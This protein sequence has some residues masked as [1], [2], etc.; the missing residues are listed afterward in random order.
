MRTRGFLILLVVVG[1]LI[2]CSAS[3]N[4]GD[5]QIISGTPH[6]LNL[7][8]YYTYDEID[9]QVMRDVFQEASRL[10]Y[11]GT[12]GQMQIGVVR[13]SKKATFNNKA[14]IWVN[15]GE[16]GAS[17]NTG[18]MGTPGL[19]ITIY[20]DQHR[21]TNNDGPDNDERGQFGIVHES[22]HYVFNLGDEYE[23]GD[24]IDPCCLEDEDSEIAC[25]M[26]GGTTTNNTRT[27]FCSQDGLGLITDHNPNNE[28]EDRHGESCW[29][30]AVDRVLSEFGIT[31]TAPSAAN[32][33]DTAMPAGHQ[34][35]AWIVVGDR[36]RYVICIDKSYSMVGSK[37]DLT[38]VA[39]DLFVD[40]VHEGEEEFLG[41]TSFSDLA[42]A[43]FPIAEVTDA[44]VKANARDAIADV[45]V[46]NNTAMGDGLRL[47]LNQ[48]TGSGAVPRDDSNIETIILLSDGVHN[49]GS[50]D[51]NDVIPD[52]KDRGVRVFTI[53]LGDPDA[54]VYPLDEETLQEI[55]DLTGGLYRHTP[56]ETELAAVYTEYAAEVRGDA[57]D[58]EATDWM[59]SGEL[60]ETKEK[61]AFIDSFT[62]E[63]T[64][65]LH[66]PAGYNAFDLKL[67]K[68]GGAM[69]DPTVA[70]GNPKI[71]HW[72]QPFYEYY[73]VRE[74]EVGNWK[75][76]VSTAAGT[77]PEREARLAVTVVPPRLR[78]TTQ[79]ICSSPLVDLVVYTPEFLYKYPQVPVIRASV[80]AGVPVAGASVEGVV[81][82]PKGFTRRVRLYDDGQFSHGDDKA[83][84]GVYSNHFLHFPKNGG[85]SF[86]LSVENKNGVEAQPDEV[87]PPDWQPKP[88][89]PFT[90]ISKS[91][92]TIS[93]VPD[94][95][96]KPEIEG[97]SPSTGRYGKS[98][99]ATIKGRGFVDGANIAFSHEGIILRRIEF[100]NSSELKVRLQIRGDATIGYSDL[101]ITNPGGIESTAQRAFRVV[102]KLYPLGLS[103]HAGATQPLG[104]LNI[105][106]EPGLSIA[107]DI[108]YRLTRSLSAE[109]LAGY[110]QFRSD[111]LE[112]TYWINL[113][114]NLKYYFQ[115]FPKWVFVNA[116]PGVYFPKDNSAEFGWMKGIGLHREILP[117]VSAEMIYN[118]HTI[119]TEGDDTTFSSI[120]LGIKYRF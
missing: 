21:W 98:L 94:D 36:L 78:F 71:I 54:A 96:P 34:D 100:V 30:T 114:L 110:H 105:P 58:S 115:T 80:V 50:E 52:I 11:N 73:R 45:E 5:G 77:S 60:G 1:L 29:E 88:I 119:F 24:G 18:G 9:M 82:G 3:V 57:V 33:P 55:A 53:G 102:G 99:D 15:W 111:K 63:A 14:D 118:H 16:S 93:G 42:H 66:W 27:E 79:V 51:P 109:L 86:R 90:R 101:T 22:G 35:I 120:W 46:D 67:Q 19:H 43:D 68:P 61:E 44:N 89:P 10:L 2:A 7:Y 117:S 13:V 69:I 76:I 65:I 97:I 112:D 107:A 64:F 85:Y 75:L 37:L 28:Q 108:E 32:P 104:D 72:E 40:L 95:L 17:A 87:M 8:L 103:M 84:D 74:P 41:V 92:I 81:T 106:Y 83:N 56:D 91:H 39:A 12:N 59:T 25:F 26:D 20:R 4:G 70:S 47:S 62:N 116:A 31:I 6:L 23:G 38:K 49:Y 113:S 48:I